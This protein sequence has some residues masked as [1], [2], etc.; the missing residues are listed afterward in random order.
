MGTRSLTTVIQTGK[1]DGK[2]YKTKLMTMYRQ[3]DGYP[4]GM[5]LD[6]AKFL[7]G[8]KV[9]NGISLMHPDK[10]TIFNGAGCLAAQLVAHFKEGPGGYYLHK[11]GQTN[12]GEEYRYEVI[13]DDDLNQP[14]LLKVI[15][16]GYMSSKGNYV[17]KA[18]T[19]YF[20]PVR[21]FEVW[22]KKYEQEV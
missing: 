9:V 6:L 10:S 17:N 15:E 22:L 19:R 20:G 11:P 7:N 4:S 1:W 14:I 18:K 12:C 21:D 8:G 13:V 16:V 3:M 2:N 5:G